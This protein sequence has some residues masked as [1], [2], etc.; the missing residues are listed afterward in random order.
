[1]Q[2]IVDHHRLEDIQLEIALRAGE[3]DGGVVAVDLHGDHGHGFALRGIDFAGHDRGARL[4]FR[5]VQF[6]Q[7]A[8]RAGGE[9]ANV[10]GDFHERG[11]QGGDGAVREDEFVVRGER[12][13]F[14]GVRAE[15]QVR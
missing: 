13:E 12:G 1:M 2:E 11:G 8:A 5:D 9:P 3:G 6:A 10:V 7:A 15:R 14:I 4:V